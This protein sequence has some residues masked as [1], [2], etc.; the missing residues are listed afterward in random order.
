MAHAP[1][2]M[3]GGACTAALVWWRM[4]GVGVTCL[5][6]ISDEETLIAEFIADVLI[7]ET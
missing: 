2:C 6:A 1:W 5:Y 7:A 4:H 3:H